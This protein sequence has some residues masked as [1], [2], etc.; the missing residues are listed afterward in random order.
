MCKTCRQQ[1]RG[2]TF[3]FHCLQF[4]HDYCDSMS[5]CKPNFICFFNAGLNS[6]A[7]FKG[8]D[9]WPKTIEKALQ[10][11]TPIL[12]TS[13]TEHEA[14][15]DLLRMQEIAGNDLIIMQEPTTNPFTSKKPERNFGSDDL[16]PLTF[17]NNSYIVVQKSNI[18]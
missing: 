6:K 18:N 3:D 2:V 4:Y 17:K 16:V 10:Q 15:F 9:T 14:P 5:Y 11:R 13:S 12:V 7:N 1:C 8:F